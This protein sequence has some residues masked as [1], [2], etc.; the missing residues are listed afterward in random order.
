M[1]HVWETSVERSVESKNDVFV[2]QGRLNE[3]MSQIRMQNHTLSARADIPCQM[4][5]AFQQEVKQVRK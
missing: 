2:L 3:L 4:D 5:P 1:F